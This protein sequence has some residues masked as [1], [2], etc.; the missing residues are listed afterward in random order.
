MMKMYE[1]WNEIMLY[2]HIFVITPLFVSF[3]ASAFGCYTILWSATN[4]EILLH[5]ILY[6]L[7]RR[8]MIHNISLL[9]ADQSHR[10]KCSSEIRR[11]SN[12]I[13]KIVNKVLVHITAISEIF[14]LLR[15][16]LLVLL[17]L[18]V[19]VDRVML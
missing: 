2:Y 14:I 13:P 8:G 10:R 5:S 1:Q 11:S 12:V 17:L 3:L 6:I 7:S 19:C 9:V 18:W 4:R 15:V 16:F